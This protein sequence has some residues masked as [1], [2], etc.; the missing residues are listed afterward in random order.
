MRDAGCG[1]SGNLAQ[2]KNASALK[3]M[4]ILGC[5]KSGLVVVFFGTAQLRSG[6]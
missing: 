5:W 2:H 4:V 1:D 3:S 6:A